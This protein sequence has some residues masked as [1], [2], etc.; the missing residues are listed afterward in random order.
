MIWLENY[1]TEDVVF[2]LDQFISLVHCAAA[3]GGRGRRC[4]EQAPWTEIATISSAGRR[5]MLLKWVVLYDSLYESQLQEET[6][7]YNHKLMAALVPT[8]WCLQVPLDFYKA[9]EELFVGMN[10]LSWQSLRFQWIC[11]PDNSFERIIKMIW[12]S[13]TVFSHQELMKS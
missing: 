3:G 9:K 5:R 4:K 1:L 2:L 11:C 10:W 13:Q 12:R 7:S 6:S 8:L